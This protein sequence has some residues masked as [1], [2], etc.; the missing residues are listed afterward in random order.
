MF[1]LNLDSRTI[2]FQLLMINLAMFVIKIVLQFTSGLDLDAFLGMYY[3]GSPQFQPVQLVTHFF[4]HGGVFHIFFN[5][6]TLVMFGA[7]LER[8]WGPQRF[9]FFYLFTA[10]GAALLHQLVQGYEIYQISG[11][12]FPETDQ[13]AFIPELGFKLSIPTIG[14]SGAVFGIMAGFALLFPNTELM[15]LFPP[16][17]VKA[18]Y[19]M[20]GLAAIELY[21]G[22]QNNPHDNVA[23]FAH[24]GGALFG[25]LLIRYWN[26][27]RNRL[28]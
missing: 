13:M 7:L 2:T 5:M 17:P 15:L 18:K 14:A 3:V 1:G 24:L 10:L 26:R 27:Q 6:Y 9:L 4:M 22:L 12:F 20:I 23:H 16:M 28:F 11:T 19:L 25:F 21:S 8:V